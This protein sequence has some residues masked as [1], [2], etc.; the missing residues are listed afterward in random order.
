MTRGLHFLSLS[1]CLL[2][3]TGLVVLWGRG[4]SRLQ[5]VERDHWI[6]ADSF[7]TLSLNS[8]SGRVWLSS[9][10]TTIAPSRM[11]GFRRN[12]TDGYHANDLPLIVGGAAPL[13]YS[14]RTARRTD[15]SAEAYTFGIPM[16]VVATL[17]LIAPSRQVARIWRDSRSVG[18]PDAT[19]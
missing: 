17:L 9:L 13:G 8:A 19:G 12:V 4:S 14:H 5:L 16:W 7:R 3:L 11:E 10:T 6:S 15:F 18:N 1:I 2:L